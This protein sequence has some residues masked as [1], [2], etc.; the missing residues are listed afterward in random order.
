MRWTSE[1]EK[2]V[3][4]WMISLLIIWNVIERGMWG[5]TWQTTFFFFLVFWFGLFSLF[6]VC[7]PTNL[8]LEGSIY[9]RYFCTFI[10]QTQEVTIRIVMIYIHSLLVCGKVQSSK[11][12]NQMSPPP[13]ADIIHPSPFFKINFFRFLESGM[14]ERFM[15]LKRFSKLAIPKQLER[16]R[17]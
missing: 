5:W 9:S 6:K 17:E 12:S 13:F 16:V 2:G 15:Y 8:C 10:W 11:L 7:Q 3:T 4:L 14:P 1:D